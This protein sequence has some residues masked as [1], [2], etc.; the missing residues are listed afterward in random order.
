MKTN[1]LCLVR[2]IVFLIVLVS[3]SPNA[4]GQYTDPKVIFEYSNDQMPETVLA[5]DIDNDGSI[6]VVSHS[7]FGSYPIHISING[8]NGQSFSNI[9]LPDSHLYGAFGNLI[10]ADL[11]KN[12][13]ADIIAI[14]DLGN[15]FNEKPNNQVIVWYNNGNRTFSSSRT[16][17]S[18]LDSG[19]ELQVLDMDSDKDLDIA[20]PGQYLEGQYRTAWLKNNGR[21]GNWQLQIIKDASG[22]SNDSGWAVMSAVADLNNDNI[23]ELFLYNGTGNGFI[24]YA[25]PSYIPKHVEIGFYA[26]FGIGFN[27]ADMDQDGDLDV[28]GGT[29]GSTKGLFVLENLNDLKF[30]RHTLSN[31]TDGFDSFIVDDLDQDG[32]PDIISDCWYGCNLTYFKNLGNLDFSKESSTMNVRVTSSKNIAVADIDK[33]GKKDLVV[34]DQSVH[35]VKWYKS[36]FAL[37]TGIEAKFQAPTVSCQNSIV[38]FQDISRGSNITKWLWDFGDGSTSSDKH[39]AHTFTKAG[40]FSVSLTVTNSKGQKHTSTQSIKIDKPPVLSGVFTFD[41]C[42]Y[43]S[44]SITVENTTEEAIYNWYYTNTDTTPF[45]SGS[46]LTKVFNDINTTLYVEKV[47]IGG[48][49][50]KRVP[51]LIRAVPRPGTPIIQ[52]V[53]SNTGPAV[54]RLSPIDSNGDIY[55]Y[56]NE[57][58]T[59]PFYVGPYYEKYFTQTESFYIE[60]G[61]RNSSCRSG[62]R[63]KVTAY[64]SSRPLDAPSF[65]WADLALS[66]SYFST[67]SN[68]QIDSYGNALALG[69]YS[70]DSLRAGGVTVS[71]SGNNKIQYLIKYDKDGKVLSGISIIERIT[72]DVDPQQFI[73]N[74]DDNIFIAGNTT[75]GNIRIGDKIIEVEGNK[76]LVAKLT[77]DGELLWY[78][79]FRLNSKIQVIKSG[80]AVSTDF[81]GQEII[82]GR[83]FGSAALPSEKYG[84]I[85]KYG[86]DGNLLWSKEISNFK[87]YSAS[88]GSVKGYGASYAVL[89]EDDNIYQYGWIENYIIVG[90]TK[91]SVPVTNSSGGVLLKYSPQGMLLWSKVISNDQNGLLLIDGKIKVKDGNVYVTGDAHRGETDFGD[92]KLDGKIKYIAKYAGDGKLQWAKSLQVTEFGYFESFNIDVD[93][94]GNVG[95]VGVFPNGN[96]AFDG[97]RIK[98]DNNVI[99]ERA[100]SWGVIAKYA[101]NGTL[102]WMRGVSRVSDLSGAFDKEGQILLH[103]AFIDTLN[104]DDIKLKGIITPP[105]QYPVNS[106]FT[107]KLGS[108][109]KALMEVNSGCVGQ[110]ITFFDLSQESDEETIIRREWDFGDGAKS[111]DK[112]PAHKYAMSANYRVTLTIYG[113]KGT[114][115]TIGKTI[116]LQSPVSIG[117][118]IDFKFY[119]I[120]GCAPGATRA[121]V[122]SPN[123]FDQYLGF[124]WYVNGQFKMT[125]TYQTGFNYN[126][127]E[128]DEVL[129]RAKKTY[130]DNLCQSLYVFEKVKTYTSSVSAS[131]KIDLNLLLINNTYVFEASNGDFYRWYLNGVLLPDV[132]SQ[133]VAK[134][135]GVYKVEAIINGCIVSKEYK[136]TV[137]GIKDDAMTGVTVLPNPALNEIVIISEEKPITHIWIHDNKGQLIKE[138]PLKSSSKEKKLDV[139]SFSPGLYFIKL[140][141]NEDRI[142]IHKIIK[143]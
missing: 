101:N 63:V 76:T 119:A 55:W 62:I 124:D 95:V 136:Y 61:A 28:I 91:I 51:V 109:F 126:L 141:V 18:N 13:F 116:S 29:E 46:T 30:K 81:F 32:F 139:S 96:V 138:I 68:L 4:F 40:T 137:T 15:Q 130:E 58:D 77:A 20:L 64:I 104:L 122:S 3:L 78:K 8:N 106:M 94:T 66:K 135:Y 125:T 31:S 67:S 84:I 128:G 47:S 39:P 17:I 127:K 89:D 72:G 112:N 56:R 98:D 99:S 69:T 22:V 36:S 117:Y 9:T 129:V 10:A 35:N 114:V 115:K 75:R 53:A 80:I 5:V 93:N 82:D 24:V 48:C 107:A 132:G 134:S 74:E 42:R 25:G 100:G 6:D 83:T 26:S 108:A 142:S 143:Q 65:V 87:Y 57:T 71:P 52:D 86:K 14:T 12:G 92:V 19:T 33:D 16:V 103:G 45:F 27:V 140:A 110:A 113:S 11:D 44:S 105:N 21:S 97:V 85:L 59:N 1:F 54:L 50:S 121:V 79:Q 123:L 37:F 70:H 7:R 49:K 43:V 90:G 73:V 38:N 34:S 60:A 41:V 118:T 133:L 2:Y 120:E 131:Y 88:S 102:S 23:P 111:T